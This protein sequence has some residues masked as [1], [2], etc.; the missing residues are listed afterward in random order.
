MSK[1]DVIVN[2]VNHH[3]KS[4]CYNP[5]HFK[6]ICLD[7]KIKVVHRNS[8]KYIIINL[9]HFNYRY[10]ICRNTYKWKRHIIYNIN[11]LIKQIHHSK[12]HQPKHNHSENHHSENHH[13][14]HS[15]SENHHSEHSHSEH[16]HSKH[17]HSEHSQ[18]EHSQP[19][20]SQP[21]HTD[22]SEKSEHENEK[23]IYKLHI[24][25]TEDSSG[26][27]I[28]K[29]ALRVCGGVIIN[30]TLNVKGGLNVCGDT[31]LKNVDASGSFNVCGDTTLKNV[32]VS[33]SLNVCGDTTLKNVDA[34]GSLNVCGDTVLKDVDVSGTLIVY[35]DTILN[36]VEVGD[37]LVRG[38]TTFCDN[39]IIDTIEPKNM[40]RCMFRW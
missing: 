11:L 10:E 1:I 5:N 6:Y 38:E 14:E 7:D 22:C 35:G 36:D 39:I 20:H 24:L 23:Q 34:S 8:G 31:T 19:E 27:D 15:H 30:K 2:Q 18:S 25:S 3:L 16:H 9:S 17:S 32:D 4:L 33:G 28:S 13:S 12:H 29:G 40:W 37:L 26:C 21:E